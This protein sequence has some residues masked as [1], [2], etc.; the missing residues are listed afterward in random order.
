MVPCSVYC[1]ASLYILQAIHVADAE[2]KINHDMVAISRGDKPLD[3][4]ALAR[5]NTP[6]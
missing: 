4:R 3:K 1:S 2:R 6:I 5:F